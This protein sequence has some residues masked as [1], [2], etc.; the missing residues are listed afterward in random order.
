[1]LGY[2]G[3]GKTT[4]SKIISKLTGATHLWADHERRLKFKNP[5]YGHQEN[6]RLYDEL[7]HKT[8]T[9]LENNTSVIFDTTFNYYKDR[10]HLR[11]IAKDCGAKTILI[12]VKTPEEIAKLRATKDA[13][14]QDSRVLGNLSDETFKRLK[15]NLEA[16]KK[17][18]DYIELDGTKI[19]EKYIEKMLDINN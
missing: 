2:P 1:M 3:S 17:N 16:P 19:S 7:N 10:Q 9:L 6:I 13:H 11:K 12:W 18:E 8:K 5:T 4:A 15:E 14:K